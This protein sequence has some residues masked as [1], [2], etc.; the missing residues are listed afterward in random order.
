[1]GKLQ[2]GFISANGLKIHYYR[3]GGDL[4][5][6]VLNHGAL[7]D[8]LC[9]PRVVEALRAEYDLIL[10]DA[11]GHGLSDQG[12]GDYSSKSRAGD[13]IGLIEALGLERPVLG[14]HSMGA[15][16][17]LHV[18]AQRPDLISGFFMEDPPFTLPGEPLFGGPA[19]QGGQDGIKRLIRALRLI[20]AAPKFISLP[21]IK[22]FMPAGTQDVIEAWLDSKQLVSEDFLETLE[23]PDWL[24][25]G[26]DEDLLERIISPGLLIYGDRERGAIVSEALANCMGERVA[27]LRIVHLA[28]ATHDIRRTQFDSYLAAVRDFLTSAARE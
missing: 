17:S 20:K 11:R 9:W 3:T 16:S 15:D 21:M 28:G 6:L 1:M 13:L 22:R 24:A 18:A 7:D 27:G 2:D 10:P 5:P 14:G 23:D 19:G 12:E 8:G 25:G 4:P 26:L